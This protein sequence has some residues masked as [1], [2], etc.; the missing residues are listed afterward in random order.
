MCSQILPQKFREAARQRVARH[1]A[2]CDCFGGLLKK[3]LVLRSDVDCFFHS[4]V[5]HRKGTPLAVHGFY[6]CTALAQ[7][8]F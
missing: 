5:V 7:F 2:H 1:D 6:T 4:W 3:R 8:F